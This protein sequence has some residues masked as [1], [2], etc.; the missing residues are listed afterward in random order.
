MSDTK[1]YPT[2]PG[3]YDISKTQDGASEI[4]D[5]VTMDAA[6]EELSRMKGNGCYVFMFALF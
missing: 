1:D 2:S 3:K 4:T 5:V 6:R